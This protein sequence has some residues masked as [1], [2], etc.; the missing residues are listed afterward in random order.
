MPLPPS[1]SPEQRQA[2]LDKAAD[3]RRQRAELKEKLKM[4]SISLAQVLDRANGDETVGKM[5][6]LAVLESLPGLGKV[7]ARRL[8][9]E[10]GIAES[11]RV[12]GLGANQREALL[13]EVVR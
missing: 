8:M 2:A 7:K 10:V 5:K 11:R 13:R 12:Q 4:G 9:D 1:L 3:A 6:V